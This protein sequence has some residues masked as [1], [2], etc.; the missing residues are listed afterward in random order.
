[1]AIDDLQT[2]ERLRKLVAR[3]TSDVSLREDLL[4]E[5]LVHLWK[6]Q[7]LEPGHTESWYLQGCRYHLQHRLAFGRSIDSPKRSSSRV[8]PADDGED[9]DSLLDVCDVEETSDVVRAEVSARDMINSMS[10]RLTKLEQAM[11]KY[12]AD[13]L[14]TG[15][16]ARRLDISHP[17]VIKYRRKI[18]ELATRLDSFSFPEYQRKPCARVRQVN[19]EKK[20]NGNGKSATAKTIN[21]VNK[22]NGHSF[23]RSVCS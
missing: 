3:L 11:L 12:L 4:Q 16:I 17:T 15:E 6:M 22:I 14:G 8:H 18:A 7:Q 9:H 23:E 1:M 21:G 19:G 13:G 20:S 2:L 10:K 5:A